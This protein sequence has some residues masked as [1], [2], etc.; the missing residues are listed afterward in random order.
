VILR[1]PP[2]QDRV[3]PID[4]TSLVDVVFILII[5]FLT[6][7]S[8]IDILRANVDLP[9]EPGDQ[10]I[11]DTSTSLIVNV[12]RRGAYI[13]EQEEVDLRTLRGMI[14]AEV[15]SAGSPAALD[16]LIRPDRDASLAPVNELASMLVDMGCSRWRIATQVPPGMEGAGP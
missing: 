10:R 11:A 2:A 4:L 15:A 7:S 3:A 12:D 6:T 14:A 1:P 9:E 8:L 13:V 5:F 16:L